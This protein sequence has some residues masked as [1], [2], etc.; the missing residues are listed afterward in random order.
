MEGELDDL[1]SSQVVVP[2]YRSMGNGVFTPEQD[3]DK[4]KVEPVDSYYPFH[5]RSNMSGV[6]GFIGIHRF[7]FCLV[8]VL[9]LSCSGV[10]TP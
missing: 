6:K 2:I 9:S 8:G 3:N 1:R 5:T 4:T 7:N 10:K